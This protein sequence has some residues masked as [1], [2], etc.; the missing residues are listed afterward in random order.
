M[1]DDFIRDL[2][3]ELV[4]AARFRAQRR[5]RRLRLPRLPRPAPAAVA[6]CVALLALLAAVAAIALTRGDHNRAS[7]ERRVTPPPPGVVVPLPLMLRTVSCPDVD[8][9]RR[10]ARG[11]L[12][13]FALLQRA[14]RADDAL[15]VDTESRLAV[16]SLEPTETR[17]ADGRLLVVPS[18]GVAGGARCGSDEGLGVCL[19]EPSERWFRCFPIADVRAGRALTRTPAGENVGIVPDGIRQVTL[20]ADG[21]MDRA[22]VVDNVYEAQLDVP[23]G[24]KVTVRFDLADA[25]DCTRE[26]AP[27]LLSRV[28][29]LSDVPE[30]GLPLPRAAREI[31]DE[32]HSQL[33]AV[34]DDA[35]RFWGGGDGVEFWVVPV[36]PYG[37]PECAP[38]TAVCVVAVV[39]DADRA[40][41]QCVLEHQGGDEAWRIGP[42]FEDRAAIYGVVPPGVTG[43]RVT[44]GDATARVD[45]RENVIGGVLPF[46]YHDGA[47]THVELLHGTSAPGA[48]AH[49]ADRLV[50]VVDASASDG[51]AEDLLRRIGD[52]GYPTLD[53]ITPGVKTQPRTA[54]HWRPG[55]ATLADA[56]RVAELVGADSVERITKAPGPPRPIAQT[57]AAI[58]VVVG[59]DS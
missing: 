52:A 17:R 35:A 36:V 12:Q 2:E 59:S 45:A 39:T 10:P 22:R 9:R 27:E 24:T 32:W 42:L 49:S 33:D 8:V 44:I 21:R 55:R 34:V 19:V 57:D 29:A 37:E 30:P 26:A 56:E 28:A 14:P 58:V 31:L 48:Q 40:D 23:A 25:P 53:T 50:G 3:E 13:D 1:S 20:T 18:L 16:T 54:V 5:S 46:P 38:A 41:A 15:L 11:E 4:A 43:A 6:L 47:R 7:D 51:A